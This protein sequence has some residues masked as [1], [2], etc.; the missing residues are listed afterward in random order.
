MP[1]LS[2]AKKSLCHFVPYDTKYEKKI[3]LSYIVPHATLNFV[4]KKGLVT[5]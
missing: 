2:I 4:K 3:I 5:M 1:P